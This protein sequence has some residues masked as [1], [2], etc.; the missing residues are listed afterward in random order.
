MSNTQSPIENIVV[1][2]LENRSLDN[3]LGTL[4]PHSTAF[5]G[6][7]LDGSMSNT[8]E[9]TPYPV[10]NE[11]SSDTFTIPAPDPGESFQDMNLQI[12]NNTD[13][14]GSASMGGF[15]NDWMAGVS[16]NY[17]AIPQDKQCGWAPSW[18]A[19]P[20]CPDP[21]QKCPG[22]NPSDI[23]FY[24]TTS[25]S[26]PQLP[27]TGWLA[28]SFAVSDAWF[29]SS[30]TQTFPNRFFVNCATAGGYVQDIDY[31]CNLEIWPKLPS[32]FELLDSP[33]SPNAANWKV[34]FHDYSI[35]TMI[36]YVLN[37]PDLVRNFDDSDFGQDTKT[38]TF[39]DDL[40]N[41]TLPKYS[42]IEPRYGGINDLPPNSNHPPANVLEGEILLA[43]VYNALAQSTYYWPR[44][45]LVITYDEHGGCFDHVVPP[46]AVEPGG[47]ELEPPSPTPFSFNRYGPRVPAILVS[48]YIKAGTV[49]RPEGFEY[50]AVSAGITTTNGVTPFDHTSIIKTVI[51]C[52]NIQVNGK[53]ANLTQRDLNAPSLLP[54]LTLTSPN[55]NNPGPVSV[56][57]PPAA[58]V[59]E[60]SNHLSDVYQAMLKR[61][62]A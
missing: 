4:Y 48:P 12:F 17:P 13:G 7:I 27:V 24:Y 18:P 3:I 43:T 45:L 21:K 39:F 9:G 8:Y 59:G 33:D 2:M 53:P 28:K 22:P 52:F 46:I 6:L 14:S 20:R 25:G 38:P 42:F 35:A 47:T 10:T 37:A 56:P 40:N 55:L 31:V 57:T 1:L 29:G 51:E 32:I 41:Q 61:F 19:L 23:M 62:G 15:V 54:A 26:A 49:L 16:T 34:Y 36:N 58:S 44:T 50:N 11:S 60:T 5:E 30:P